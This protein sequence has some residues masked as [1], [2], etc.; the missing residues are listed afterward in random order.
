MKVVTKAEAVSQ[1]L[2]YYF[3]GKPC[4]N[5]HTSRRFTSDSKG[6]T[7]EKCYREYHVKNKERIAITHAKSRASNRQALCERSKSYRTNNLE[8]CKKRDKQRYENK[9]EEVLAKQKEYRKANPHIGK[10]QGAKR[11]ARKRNALVSWSQS[12]EILEFYKFCPEGFTVDHIEPLAAKLICGLHVRENLQ[13]L[14][15]SKNCSKKNN[16][17]SYRQVDGEIVEYYV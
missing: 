1:N 11:R 10:L 17:T 8:H 13:Y 6:R 5:G 16:F 2:E 14:T 9:K 7:C 12:K 3:T 15:F 4:K